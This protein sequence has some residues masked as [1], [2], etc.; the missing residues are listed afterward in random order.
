M[1]MAGMINANINNSK[2]LSITDGVVVLAALWILN[3]KINDDVPIKKETSVTRFCVIAGTTAIGAPRLVSFC[4]VIA[5][6]SSMHMDNR[7]DSIIINDKNNS[8][9][10]PMISTKLDPLSRRNL[11]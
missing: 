4:S 7:D 10:L 1:V 5:L 11:L 8:D 2:Y 3:P 6:L 9:D